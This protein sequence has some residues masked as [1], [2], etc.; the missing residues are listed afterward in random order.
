[1]ARTELP[2]LVSGPNGS[3]KTTLLRALAGLH[4]PVGGRIIWTGLGPQHHEEG[5]PFVS[6]QGHQDPIKA[7]EPVARQLHFW[8]DLTGGARGRLTEIVARVGLERQI[9]L[10]A[11]VLSAGQR[12]RASLARLI[13]EDR[14]VWLLDEP[15]APLDTTGRALL[16][17]LL[18]GHVARGGLIIAA[19]HDLL[20]GPAV[21]NVELAREDGPR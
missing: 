2:V 9:D 17:D 20:P 1:M 3:G 11:G 4:T 14:P 8:A 12:R 6:F 16:G 10:P 18:G 19:T 7:G 15:S 21:H 5:A 13:M